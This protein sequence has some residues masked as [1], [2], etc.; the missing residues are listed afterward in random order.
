[1]ASA[2]VWS[3]SILLLAVA[4]SSS[5]SSTSSLPL[6]AAV[7]ATDHT[8]TK[9]KNNLLP[10]H[11]DHAKEEMEE[12][13]AG[14]QRGSSATEKVTSLASAEEEG[15]K[16]GSNWGKAKKLDDDDDDDDNDDP[17]HGRDSDQ[18]QDQDHDHDHDSDSDHDHDSDSDHDRNHDSDSDH[19]RDSDSD[20][21]RDHDSDSD[22][23]RDHDSDSDHDDDDNDESE[24]K[25]KH[26]AQGRK[27]APGGKRD[28][29]LPEVAE[30]V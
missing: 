24:K 17:D 1:M 18:D 5:I 10:V 16:T 19:D 26:A 12:A 27:G 9:E 28:N 25:N 13:K 3:A 11:N 4:I 20:H 29:Q 7:K 30:K 22:H 15:K 6:T 8:I 21:D 2:A 23:D 14:V